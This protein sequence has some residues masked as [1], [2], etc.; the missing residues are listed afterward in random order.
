[1][2]KRAA[3]VLLALAIATFSI[4]LWHNKISEIPALSVFKTSPY[5]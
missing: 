3:R 2:T 4:A 5:V 1:M